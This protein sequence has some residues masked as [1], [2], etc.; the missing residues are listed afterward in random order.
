MSRMYGSRGGDEET[1]P[2]GNAPCPYPNDTVQGLQR[3]GQR[4]AVEMTQQHRL[5]QGQGGGPLEFYKVRL[6]R[7][8]RPHQQQRVLPGNGLANG[9]GSAL[10]AVEAVLITPHAN[11]VGRQV[12]SERGNGVQIRT[13]VA[14]E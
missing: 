4:R 8:L 12:A 13:G 10:A 11:T 5:L 6:R 1:C 14:E 3:R 7:L 9:F 2:Q